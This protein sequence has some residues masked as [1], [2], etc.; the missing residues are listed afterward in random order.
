LIRVAD[1]GRFAGAMNY[2][3]LSIVLVVVLVRGGRGWWLL[4]IACDSIFDV[5]FIMEDII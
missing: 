2:D 4:S 1:G 3:G 5:K